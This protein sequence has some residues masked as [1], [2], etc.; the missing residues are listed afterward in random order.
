MNDFQGIDL[1]VF[2][3]GPV[4]TLP[5]PHELSATRKTHGAQTSSSSLKKREALRQRMSAF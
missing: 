3:A 5:E 1:Q 4:Q 2:G